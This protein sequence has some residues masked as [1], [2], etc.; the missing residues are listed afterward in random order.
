LS[1][2][3]DGDYKHAFD[4]LIMPIATQFNP[5][6]VLVSAGFDAMKDD[7]VGN[8]SLSPAIYAY[9]TKQLQELAHGKLAL[10]LEGGYNLETMMTASEAC[11]KA[12]LGYEEPSRGVGLRHY[13]PETTELGREAVRATYDVAREYWD[14]Q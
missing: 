5:D 13:D 7:P 10:I 1:G 4:N 8:L 6:I 9:M 14:I 11:M 2:I 3:S 12:L